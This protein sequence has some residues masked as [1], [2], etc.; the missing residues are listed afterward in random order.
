[1]VTL[2]PLVAGGFGFDFCLF[3]GK[4]LSEVRCLHCRASSSSSET[5]TSHVFMTF[6]LH[7]H[8]PTI[9]ARWWNLNLEVA[10]SADGTAQD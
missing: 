8:F 4:H 7:K 2:P 6:V 1:M 5:C 10:K 9:P 3:Q